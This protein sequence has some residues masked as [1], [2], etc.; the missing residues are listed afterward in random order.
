M[1]DE[2]R[3]LPLRG[4]RHDPGDR[5]RRAAQV[6]RAER[7][8]GRQGRDPDVRDVLAVAQDEGLDR[9]EEQRAR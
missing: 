7:G 2:A 5:R 9:G 1:Q 4:H 3:E 6:E 8:L